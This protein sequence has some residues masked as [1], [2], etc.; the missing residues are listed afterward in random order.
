MTAAERKFGF[1]SSG[2]REA[3][4]VL[5]TSHACYQN[6]CHCFCSSAPL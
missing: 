3:D 4:A 5:M 6:W 1:G 2:R